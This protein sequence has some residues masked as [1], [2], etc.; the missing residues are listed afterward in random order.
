[1]RSWIVLAALALAGGGSTD[2]IDRRVAERW[3]S[4]GITP[5]RA[6]DD[7]EFF[8]R[9]SLDLRGVIPT[10]DEIRKFAADG[11]AGKR[12]KAA[13]AW[14]RSE[15]CATFWSRRWREDL[16][17]QPTGKVREVHEGFRGW[18]RD[19]LRSNMSYDRFVKRMLTAKGPSDLDP[20]VGFL[21]AGLFNARDEGVKDVVERAA[22]L[23]LGMQIRCA[24]CHDHPF[25]DWTQQDFYGMAS[26]F[27]QARSEVR[28]GGGAEGQT[29]WVVDDLTRGEP[30]LPGAAK[31]AKKPEDPK[32][33]KAPGGPKPS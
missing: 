14:L 3:Q 21:A 11:D 28:G 26:F 6:A 13:D 18:I 8:R 22:R 33:P 20:A 27:W 30:G 10:P 1:M 23:F 9:L 7:Y 5:A 32:A 24:E 25:D 17:V 15:E 19:A 2:L 31:G 4:E 16:T 29:G 12:E